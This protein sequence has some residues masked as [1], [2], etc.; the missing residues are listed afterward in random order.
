MSIPDQDLIF[1]ERPQGK[2]DLPKMKKEKGKKYQILLRKALQKR[3][4]HVENLQARFIK[5][6]KKST[7]YACGKRRKSSH[8]ASKTSGVNFEEEKN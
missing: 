5:K 8:Q 6:R 7:K 2:I 3:T 4:P 1:F